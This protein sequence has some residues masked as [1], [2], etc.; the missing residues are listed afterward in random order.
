MNICIK[1]LGLLMICYQRGAV[2]GIVLCDHSETEP[3]RSFCTVIPYKIIKLHF[4][5]S[6]DTKDEHTFVKK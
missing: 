6:M 5:Q 2:S 1:I 3:I 4:I